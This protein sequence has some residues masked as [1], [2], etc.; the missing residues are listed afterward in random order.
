MQAAGEIDSSARPPRRLRFRLLAHAGITLLWS[1]SAGIV[2]ILPVIARREFGAG[3]G[4]MLL[5]TMAIPAMLVLS[6]FWGELFSRI[7]LGRYVAVLW[8]TAFVPIAL[9]A[10]ARDFTTLLL[11]YAAAAAGNAGWS[12]AHGVLLK[13]LYPPTVF[14]RAFAV[15]TAVQLASAI[16]AALLIGTWLEADSGSFRYSFPLLAGLQGIGA[17]LIVLLARGHAPPAAPRAP[18]RLAA[19]LAPVARMH[20]VLRADRPF[21]RYEQAFMTYGFGYMICEALLPLIVTDRLGMSYEEIAAASQAALRFGTLAMVLPMGW[22]LDRVGPTRI[23]ALSFTV[24]A[25]YPLG[26][27]IATDALGVGAA[28]AAYGVGLAGVMLG[29]MIGPVSFARDASLAPQYVSIHATLVGVR[30]V[31]AQGL[32]MGLYWLSGGFE[33]PLVLAAVAFVWAGLQM[34]RLDVTIRNSAALVAAP[35]ATPSTAA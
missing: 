24:L 27:L 15:L 10:F 23:S 18:L 3:D 31:V 20:A 12:T 19:A 16:G 7:S 17:I 35:A 33:W 25:S 34:W 2:G 1:G 21:R 8:I 4:Q 29:W 5:I 26:L 22:L 14:G 32:G 6:I 11:L 30:G 9:I 13:R 28:S